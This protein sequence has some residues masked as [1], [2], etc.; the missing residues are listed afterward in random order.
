[1]VEIN[2]PNRQMRRLRGKTDTV[3]AEAAGR[4]ALGGQATARPKMSDGPVECI[5]M[6]QVVRRSEVKVRTQ[7]ANQLV[8]LVV[9]APEQLKCQLRGLRTRA[10]VKVCAALRPGTA[11]TTTAYAKWA[12]G[13]LAHRYQTLN[14]EITQLDAEIRRLCTRANPALLAAPGVGS[15]TAAGLLVAAGDNPERMSTEAAFAALCG[16]SPVQASSGQ[17]VRHRLNRGGDRQANNALWRIATNHMRHDPR[18]I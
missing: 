11:Q 6:L 9:T 2:R 4:A 15:D 8:S 5:R 18:S 3:D 1:M 16:A 13:N 10:Q 17:T 14:T 7:A 12:L